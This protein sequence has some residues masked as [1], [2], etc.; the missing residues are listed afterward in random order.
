VLASTSRDR[1]L[2]LQRGD[3]LF[4]HFSRMS[5]A[6]IDNE[7]LNPVDEGLLG[8]QA[9]AARAHEHPHLLEQF[10]LA[11]RSRMRLD[12]HRLLTGSLYDIMS[13]SFNSEL[14]EELFVISYEYPSTSR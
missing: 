13:P 9:V 10:G 11:R 12:S 7:A 2:L 14:D 4:V 6:V 8:A 5:F 3:F 1:E